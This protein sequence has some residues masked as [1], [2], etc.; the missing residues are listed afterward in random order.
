MAHYSRRQMMKLSAGALL[1]AGLW[2]RHAFAAETASKPLK[3]IQVNDLHYVDEKCNPF[4]EGLV[5]ELNKVEGAA[6]VLIVGDLVD[7]GTTK[8]CQTIKEILSKLK[9]PYY[10]TCGNHDPQTQTD[11]APFLAA[12]GDKLNTN[13]EIDGWQF[14]GMD[15]S[16]GTKSG[17]FDCHKE[18]LDF[19]ASLPTKL[20]KNK[21]TF[22]YTH[23][24]LGPGVTNRLRNADALLDPF[25]QLNVAAIFTGHHHAFTQKTVLKDSI[26]TTDVCCSFK[27][28]NHDSTFQKGFFI[29]EA[30][31]GKW[32]RTFTEYGTDF[33]GAATANNRPLPATRPARPEDQSRPWF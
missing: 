12:F 14:V 4:F 13:F 5:T 23:F 33:K 24:P 3:F 1:A 26:V 25:K 21:P 10:V 28:A 20:D 18:T 17:N 9:V 16:D 31:D 7:N 29:L 32:K 27:R 11:R 2:P 22:V 8:Q 6:H 19:A 15:T 30:A